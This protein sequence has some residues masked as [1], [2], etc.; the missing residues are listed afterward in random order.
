MKNIRVYIAKD[1]DYDP[2][3]LGTPEDLT[4]TPGY[5]LAA[6]YW[7]E[8]E[9]PKDENGD[10]GNDNV[11]MYELDLAN[12]VAPNLYH[13]IA[14]GMLFEND[15]CDDDIYYEVWVDEELVFWRSA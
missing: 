5:G 7:D 13:I 9:G 11:C 10:S 2:G 15:W 3:I 8:G 6:A 1:V 12:D 14:K 4:K